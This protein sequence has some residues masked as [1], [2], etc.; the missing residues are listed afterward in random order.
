MGLALS[1]VRGYLR[2]TN[3]RLQE[4]AARPL[5]LAL[6]PAWIDSPGAAQP[7]GQSG[8]PVAE[9]PCHEAYHWPVHPPRQPRQQQQQ[10]LGIGIARTSTLPVEKSRRVKEG[11]RPGCPSC[12]ARR[13]HPALERAGGRAEVRHKLAAFLSLLPRLLPRNT[14]TSDCPR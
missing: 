2:R 1:G 7:C 3:G 6:L 11:A 8:R 4:G 9:V 5:R 13:A 10:A 12:S 14:L